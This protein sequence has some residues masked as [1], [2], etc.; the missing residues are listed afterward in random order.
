VVAV[1]GA[2][3]ASFTGSEG[4]RGGN[5]DRLKRG[6]LLGDDRWGL[7]KEGRRP[8]CGGVRGGGGGTRP[9]R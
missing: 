7:E 1:I 3:M 2:F 9:V 4:G 5:Y 6:E 8:W